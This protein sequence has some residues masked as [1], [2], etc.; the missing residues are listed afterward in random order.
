M[1]GF[2][3]TLPIGL[4]LDGLKRQCTGR[5]LSIHEP[6]AVS[7]AEPCKQGIESRET[8]CEE[9]KVFCVLHRSV[10]HELFTY[11]D[12]I[13]INLTVITRGHANSKRNVRS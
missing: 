11:S 6:E 4:G 8:H 9:A 3:C 7:R 1:E 10:A 2:C 13:L 5:V 12:G